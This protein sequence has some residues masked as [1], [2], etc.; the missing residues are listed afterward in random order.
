ML[1]HRL[2][3]VLSTL[4]AAFLL[5]LSS[6]APQYITVNGKVL[7][8]GAGFI[9]AS[10][11]TPTDGL[12]FNAYSTY[13][14]RVVDPA[15]ASNASGGTDCTVSVAGVSGAYK[16]YKTIQYGMNDYL[17]QGGRR[18]IVKSA[19]YIQTDDLSF[20]AATGVGPTA[21]V[22]LMGDPGELTF[23]VISW[24]GTAA[25]QFV[26][27]LNNSSE[28]IVLRKLEIGFCTGDVSGIV[29]FAGGW[30][31]A[32]AVIEY[33]YIHDLDR[34]DDT[35]GAAIAMYNEFPDTGNANTGVQI[36]YNHL[37][38]VDGPSEN[39]C[40][41]QT[42]HTALGEVHHNKIYG[43]NAGIYYKGQPSTLSPDGYW[44]TYSNVFDTIRGNAI[45]YA[46]Q[47]GGQ[48]GYYTGDEI[49][50]NLGLEVAGSMISFGVS[51][52]DEVS[53]DISFYN[54][55]A[56]DDVG[57]LVFMSGVDGLKIW[58]NASAANADQIVLAGN[59]PRTVLDESNYNAYYSVQGQNWRTHYGSG[60][61]TYNLVGWKAAYPGDDQ[62]G[63]AMEPNS[64]TF[65]SL[66]SAF[67]SAGTGN[68]T[69]TGVLL[70]TGKSGT[71]IGYNSADSGPG[72]NP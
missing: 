67:V 70:G 66:S 31:Y 24:A 37:G 62:L 54:N 45:F 63:A 18:L 33:S 13:P 1:R 41:I 42:F 48:P 56:S 51:E 2:F 7:H 72:W 16:C 44:K 8:T 35:N 10:A 69:G 23:P 40:A 29:K 53:T 46:V 32:N 28:Y 47:G 21:R 58:N 36:R 19:T 3:A 49:Y 25:K 52:T 12:Y 17:T 61:T 22:V 55:T 5:P 20:P 27:N 15:T 6:A 9:S 64:I 71:N 34:G 11:V 4:F 30:S 38:N 26:P 60:T 50:N 57:A 43:V 68:W 59:S 14:T 39:A 65:A